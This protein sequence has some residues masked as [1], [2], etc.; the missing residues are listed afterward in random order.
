M[1]VGL[2]TIGDEILI[3]QTVDTNASHIAKELNLIGVEIVGKHTV[4]DNRE[5]I[6]EGLTALSSKADLVITTGGL[7][8][9]K[10]DITKEVI[11]EFL[12]RSMVFNQDIYDLIVKFFKRIG[13]TP[14]ESHRLQAYMPEGV[15]LLHN[16]MG[17][18]PGMWFEQGDKYFCCLPGV[19][20][21][22]KFL[23]E[24]QVIPKIR[25]YYKAQIGHR[26]LITA[27][28]GETMLADQIAD[29][30]KSLPDHLKI[31]YLPDL[32]VVRIRLTGRGANI[33]DLDKELDEW[34]VQ[35]E[36]RLEKYAIGYNE[37]N[38]SSALG[39]LLTEKKLKIGTAESCTGGAI[40]HQIVKNPGASS[41]YEGSM[42]TYSYE[43]KTKHLAVAKDLLLTYGAVS[44]ETVV[45][46]LE[47]LFAT[48]DIDVG[49]AVSGIAGPGGGTN[50]KPVGTIW[51]SYGDRDNI[52]TKKIQ[53]SKFRALNI[54]Y[55]SNVAINLLLKFLMQ[56]KLN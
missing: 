13:R 22:M 11:G 25:S 18:A 53:A 44:E 27:G 23:I 15:L 56:K 31:A 30:E 26:T 54:K 50:D 51:I 16:K 14:S 46:M 2:L 29:I 4:G 42:I 45:Q 19:P 55:A 28:T 6:I 8:P 24:D 20:Y 1:K 10:D 35:I 40:A 5:D 43:S 32:G 38:L 33:I 12:N 49:I 41:Y 17:T 34:F 7:G 21:E 9:T 39:K 52:Q 48:M 37:E 3:G 36:K 47:G